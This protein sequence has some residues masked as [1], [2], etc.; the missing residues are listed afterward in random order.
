MKYRRLGRTGLYVS[1]M[2][3]GTMTFGGEG[4]WKVVGELDQEAATG[5]VRTALEHGGNFVDTADVYS[6][7]RSEE[8]TGQAIRDLGLKRSDVVV[9]TK[10]YGAMGQGPN[11][12]GASRGHI[13][14]GVKRS[15]E[16]LGLD[17]IDLYQIHADDPV[18][19]VEE[20]M[21]AL[22]DL[23]REGLVRYVGCS[24]W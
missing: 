2:C 15:L 23:V 7:G 10:V 9:A 4:F 17:H 16:R 14:D 13:M 6:E 1:E 20:T 3:L 11:D 19:P 5:L 12:R 22:G 21:V 8:I 24:N 18:T